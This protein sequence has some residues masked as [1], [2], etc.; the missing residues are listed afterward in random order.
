MKTLSLP[1]GMVFMALVLFAFLAYLVT[2][3]WTYAGSAWR[4]GLF[5]FVST[6]LCMTWAAVSSGNLSME[7]SS[8]QPRNLLLAASV[9]LALNYLPLSGDLSWRGDEEW[10][11]AQT[12]DLGSWIARWGILGPIGLVGALAAAAAMLWA[13]FREQTL[14][15]RLLFIAL[16]PSVA[17][18]LAFGTGLISLQA[19]SL[20]AFVRYA[21]VSKYFSVLPVVLMHPFCGD[22]PPEWA[23][24]LV[25]IVSM[26]VLAWY[27]LSKIQP[28][29]FLARGLAI[30]ALATCPSL[31]Y[32]SSVLYLE[33]PV[34]FL[35]TVVCF[36]AGNLLRK[37]SAEIVA[38][39]GWYALIFIGF[40]KET[41]F[42][43][44]AA[45]LFCRWIHTLLH[46]PPKV[47]WLS[48]ALGEAVVAF[49]VLLPWAHY[50]F[51]RYYYDSVMDCRR[52]YHPSV[53][54]LL[55]PHIYVVELKSLAIQFGSWLVLAVAGAVMLAK[56]KEW[57]VLSFLASATAAIIAFHILDTKTLVG[58]AR[59][60]LLVAPMI[61]ASGSYCLWDWGSLR[62]WV[63]GI[64][65][66]ATVAL[67]L[68]LTPFHGDGSRRSGWG[69][70]PFSGVEFSYPFR[71]AIGWVSGHY[72]GKRI[73]IGGLNYPY[74]FVK[75][76]ATKPFSYELFEA[77]DAD[78]LNKQLNDALAK[79]AAGG[80]DA[81]LFAVPG[82][83]TPSLDAGT[84]WHIAK[85][86]ENRANR[87]V[88]VA[89]D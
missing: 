70:T 60:N 69:D 3:C 35:M 76:Y 51:Y 49:G 9:V 44:L 43:F 52:G 29:S 2:P 57:G 7:R 28:Q 22:R 82:D 6:A 47:H 87:L 56:R 19:L 63:L 30:L 81:L 1:R 85:V 84:R 5:W 71:S 45:F 33:M 21:F 89:R 8:A 15:R 11:V 83:A 12:L 66:I 16:I 54:N 14:T 32:Y 62:Q 72:E 41:T 13:G 88:L 59:F 20:T 55:D 74:A 50:V 25:P 61:I 42:A 31:F 23:L 34:V 46:R 67:N 73:L 68:A 24:R 36:S 86:F 64:T 58:Y 48:L 80:F 37:P 78:P 53:S 75:Y 10:H 26:M 4:V 40:L 77:R 65:L 38:S 79:A 18:L 39:P 27:V 17:V